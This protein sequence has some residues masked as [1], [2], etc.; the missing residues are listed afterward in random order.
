M[1]TDEQRRAHPKTRAG[2]S[3]RPASQEFGGPDDLPAVLLWGVSRRDRDG[4]SQ[5]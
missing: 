1:E 5:A 3:E 2:F 4:A